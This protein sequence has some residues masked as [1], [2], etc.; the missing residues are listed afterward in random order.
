MKKEGYRV[1]LW[2]LHFKD[3]GDDVLVT[4]SVK[5]GKA[6]GFYLK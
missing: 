4:W 2:S 1:Y 3:G 6:G 5:N